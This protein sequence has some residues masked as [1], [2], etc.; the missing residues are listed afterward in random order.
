MSFAARSV[1]AAAIRRRGPLTVADFMDL[2]L[3]DPEVGYYSLRA[4]RSGRAGDY[5]TSVDV[6]TVFGELLAVQ[7]AEM[8]RV[9]AAGA[10]TRPVDLV[11]AAAGDGR[12]AAD[13][14]EAAAAHD[15]RFYEAVR[16]SLVEV[17]P[18][19]RAAQPGTLGRHTA[20]LAGTLSSLPSPV[21]GIIYANELL[22]ALPTHLVVMDPD[23]GL[24]EVYVDLKGD[25][26]VEREGPPSTP[27]LADHLRW[28]G[29]TLPPGSRAEINLRARD[30]IRSAARCLRRGFLLL[31]D[32]GHEAAELL[33][34]THATGTLTAFH[35]HT[36][37]AGTWLV[38]PGSA[39][40]TSH[41]DLTMVR[42]TA[43]EEGLDTIGILD[44]TYFLLG[45]GLAE[46]LAAD[47]GDGVERLKRR[48]A[49]KTLMLPGGLGSVQKVMIFGRSVGKPALRGCSFKMRVT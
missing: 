18:A 5:F 10:A 22:D 39:D 42:R 48:L 40:I 19:A 49:L 38:D 14:M 31:I 15:P 41:V 17:S 37:R 26:L 23:V 1:I 21:D 43:E 32:Y 35:R 47:A 20:K 27:A 13:V 45:L 30:W 46:R 7:L 3:Y 9:L 16:L 4:R 11:E 6:G 12:L 24:R 36:A 25:T 8:W 34:P 28:L 44:Q 29:V 33:S 2:A